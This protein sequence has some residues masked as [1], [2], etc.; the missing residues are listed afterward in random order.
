MFR[1]NVSRCF[2]YSPFVQWFR[3]RTAKVDCCV[4][5]DDH[6]GTHLS[7]DDIKVWNN[8]RF[9]RTSAGNDYGGESHKLCVFV[10]VFVARARSQQKHTHAGCIAAQRVRGPMLLHHTRPIS[11]A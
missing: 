11:N 6:I 1:S 2:Y 4:D 10:S 8:W 3:L 9:D 7:D 5:G